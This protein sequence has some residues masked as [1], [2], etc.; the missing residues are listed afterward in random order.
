MGLSEASLLLAI[1]RDRLVGES[2][3]QPHLATKICNEYL[4]WP[5]AFSSLRVA[6]GNSTLVSLLLALSF[7]WSPECLPTPQ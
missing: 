2:D 6:L 4:A 7:L 3:M 1:G 5:T